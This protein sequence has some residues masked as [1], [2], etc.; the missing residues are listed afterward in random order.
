M[1]KNMLLVIPLL[2]FLTTS[3]T[4]ATNEPNNSGSS[5]TIDGN[6]VINGNSPVVSA[7]TL[8]L[9]NVP[10]GKTV[11][12]QN[13]NIEIRGNVGDGATIILEVQGSC[14][15]CGAIKV[16][17]IIGN[18]VTINSSNS[19]IFGDAG[20]NLHAHAGNSVHGKEVESGSD[21]NGGNSVDI[22]T[23]INSKIE[24]GNSV[25]G[26]CV[27]NST[28]NAGNSVNFGSHAGSNNVTAGNSKSLGKP[29]ASCSP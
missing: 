6:S 14:H 13:Q 12:G 1:R 15:N 11:K 21:I 2:L 29:F 3:C 16:N 17:G 19:L 5:I 25:K 8:V 4:A 28:V 22:S 9:E 27:E 7:K 18:N 26:Y 24:A 20:K 23:V 10:A